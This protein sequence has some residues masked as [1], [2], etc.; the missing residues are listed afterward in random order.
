MI[1]IDNI[2]N[3]DCL[4]GMALMPDRSVDA[5]VCDLP[6]IDVMSIF[7]IIARICDLTIYQLN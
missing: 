7:I 1:R 5:V 2:Y 3:M 6:N 4:S